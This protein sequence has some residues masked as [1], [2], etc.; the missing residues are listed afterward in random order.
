MRGRARNR[1]FE[2]GLTLLEVIVA[3]GLLGAFTVV[4]ARPIQQAM[5][6]ANAAGDRAAAL[7]YAAAGI[8]LARSRAIENWDM[9]S[10]NMGIPQ[11]ELTTYYDSAR[12]LRLDRSITAQPLVVSPSNPNEKWTWSIT[13]VVTWTRD[14]RSA[15]QGAKVT[16]VSRQS[17]WLIRNNS[18]QSR[19]AAGKVYK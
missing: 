16:L 12:H 15:A 13:S 2:R 10:G 4:G 6:A 19:G 18:D 8:E 7:R 5:M 3:A 14:G 9:T 17:R 1:R 11:A